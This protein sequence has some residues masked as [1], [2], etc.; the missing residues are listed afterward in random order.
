LR[1]LAQ[2]AIKNQEHAA[3]SAMPATRNALNF[4][5]PESREGDS[6]ELTRPAAKF[7]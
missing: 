5:Q 3:V 6:A 2:P 1:R 4:L 7:P